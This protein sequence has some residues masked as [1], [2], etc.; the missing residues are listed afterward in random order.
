MEA[1]VPSARTRSWGIRMPALGEAAAPTAAA[2]ALGAIA[3]GCLLIVLASGHGRSFLA[4]TLRG[5]PPDWMTWPFSGFWT[6]H[7]MDR[8][9]LE[10]ELLVSLVG[11]SACYL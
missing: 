1:A 10:G 9:S 7:R 3:T 5:A 2:V 6:P 4:P 11:L 8:G